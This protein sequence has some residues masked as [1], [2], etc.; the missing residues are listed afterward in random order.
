[1][2]EATRAGGKREGE[3]DVDYVVIGSGFGG[4]VSAL[5]LTEKGYSV[6]VLE[7]GRRFADADLPKDSFDLKR[8]YWNPK[9]GLRG[10]WKLTTFKDVLV[11]SGTSV[12]GG[13]NVYAMTLYTPPDRF[14]QDPQ[15]ASMADWKTTLSPHFETAQRMLGVTDVRR[16]DKADGWLKEYADELGVGESYRKTR[17]GA[18]LDTPGKTVADPYFGGEGPE[19]TGCTQCGRCMIGCPV[20]AKNTLLKNYLWFAEQGGATISP[21]RTVVDIRPL[22]GDR[23]ATGWLVEHEA[24]GRREGVDRQTLRVRG[25]VVSGGALGS[26]T[27]LQRARLQGSLPHISPMLG[28]L[29]RT[30]SESILGVT[31]PPE[32]AKGMST[33]VAISSSIYPDPDTHIETVVFGKAGGTNKFMMALLTGDGSRVTRP[34]KL[35]AQM[36]R[37]PRRWMKL[38]LTKGWSERT[39]VILVMQSLD[40]ALRLTAKPRRGG[41]VKLQTQQSGKANPTYIAAG[42]AF[43]KWLAERTGGIAASGALEALFNIPATA[44]FLGG[45]PIGPSPEKG[46]VDGDLRVYGYENLMVVDGAAMPANVGVNPSLTITALAEHAMASVPPADGVDPATVKVRGAEPIA[47]Q[48]AIAEPAPLLQI[49]NLTAPAG[50]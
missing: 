48:T 15:W 16:D 46:V 40:N 22:D 1:M 12:G 24:S 39:V 4:S 28:E 14:F 29:V 41:G 21:D 42:N 49:S 27:L 47:G 13:S 6:T 2:N 18:Y 35:L 9:V 3:Y 34:I 32:Q 25:I 23:G 17:V 38:F 26:N 11:M 44:H 19:R 37:H 20:G 7:Q 33:R 50:H 31:V 5:R 30:N 45:V 43:A 8:Y 10:I 36:A